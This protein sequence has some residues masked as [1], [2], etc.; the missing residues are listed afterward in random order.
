MCRGNYSL[1]KLDPPLL[2]NLVTDASEMYPLDVKEYADVMNKINDLKTKFES[3][4]VW[5]ES[6]KHRGQSKAE[7][8]CAKPGCSPF[9]TCCAVN[10]TNS[11][12]W[13]P[14]N[15]M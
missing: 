13:K 15:Y 8:P 4:M 14:S 5:G 11:N 6:Q 2:Y 3:T 12:W 1:H 10:T 7:E 9:P